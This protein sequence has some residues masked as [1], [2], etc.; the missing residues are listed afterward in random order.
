MAL[1]DIESTAV[2][3]LQIPLTSFLCLFCACVWFYLYDKMI[4][5]CRFGVRYDKIIQDKQWWIR[6]LLVAPVCH[7][8]IFHLIFC[9]QALWYTYEKR[10]ENEND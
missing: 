1:E 8:N 6:R 7:K 5:N 2:D 10:K 4:Y 3:A 9:V